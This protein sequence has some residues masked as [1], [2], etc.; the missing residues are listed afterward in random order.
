VHLFDKRHVES[1]DQMFAIIAD[2]T[3]HSLR[4]FIIANHGD[5]S[6]RLV[7]AMLALW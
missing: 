3:D 6:A 5:D 4:F 2:S 7:F 1:A